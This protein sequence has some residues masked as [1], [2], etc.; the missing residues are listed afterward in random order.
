LHCGYRSSDGSLV[1][2]G[3]TVVDASS[4]RNEITVVSLS[5]EQVVQKIAI[6]GD[7]L[8][9]AMFVHPTSRSVFTGFSDGLVKYYDD[10]TQQGK[11]ASISVFQPRQSPIGPADCITG[12]GF[13]DQN[14][15]ST[16]FSS[17]TTALR[18][19]D[20]RNASQPTKVVELAGNGSLATRGSTS[21]MAS[22]TGLAARPQTVSAFAVGLYTELL[23]AAMSD[24]I[25]EVYNG[26]AQPLTAKP[27]KIKDA[28]QG[29]TFI[30]PMRPMV[31]FGGEL[32]IAEG[33]SQV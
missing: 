16:V 23:A 4:G 29:A 9:T 14:G 22:L 30:H 31:C 5:E 3:P 17:T 6:S 27:L 12:V 24:G 15:A 11:L 21:M 26:R 18:L 19:Y 2:G 28:V 33:T 8:L 10:R 13:C 25:C 1:Y 32:V 20:L 7:A